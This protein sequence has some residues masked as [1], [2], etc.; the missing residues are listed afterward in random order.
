MLTNIEQVLKEQRA[1]FTTQ[2]TK[3]IHFRIETLKK[4]KAAIKQKETKILNAMYHDLRKSEFE[5]YAIE[6]GEVYEDLNIHIK[7]LKKWAAPEHVRTNIKFFSAKSY[8]VREPYGVVL[9]IAPWNYPFQLAIGPLVGAIASGNCA[10]V[11][12]ANYSEATSDIIE[13]LIHDIFP[14][15]YV[16]VFNG[17]RD[18][19]KELLQQKYDS[20]FFTGSPSLGRIVMEA[21]SKNLTP[22][23]LELGG[24]SPCI[25][26][27]DVNVSLAAKR[28]AWGKFT[29][30]GQ[31]CVCP[32]YV[33]VHSSIKDKF[34]HAMK[35]A[36]R[37]LYGDDP[38]ESPDFGRIIN[39]KEFTRLEKLLSGQK[40]YCGGV[41]NSSERYISPTILTD[42]SPD[43]LV[44]QEEIFGPILP[45]LQFSSI[46]KVIDFVNAR[47]KPLALYLFTKDKATEKAVCSQISFGGGCIN[48]TLIHA[49]NPNL[50]FG[51]VG[52]SG[53][54]SYHGRA[55][56]ETFSH[57]KSILKN[58]TLID[59]KLRYP[60][61]NSKKL[62]ILK[63][64]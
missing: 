22:V 8:V 24:K 61:Y 32:D 37:E 34:L 42:V 62:A 23:T 9:I 60:P 50:P 51:G 1:F 3:D 27:A 7:K 4:L 38:A 48:D 44:M 14:A 15:S 52:S 25:V 6:L 21:A 29:N 16:S 20:I 5:G 53:M 30:A 17:G 47:P 54:G 26:N 33:L 63:M 55:S 11:K 39:A 49:G 12:P 18:V 45:V 28:I 2:K 56:F 31:T 35:N 10:I 19:I 58:T 46:N 59:I 36:I 13:E 41:V 40:I 43:S 57:R 64:L